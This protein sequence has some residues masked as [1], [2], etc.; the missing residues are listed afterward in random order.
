MP[1]WKPAFPEHKPFKCCAAWHLRK[2]ALFFAVYEFIGGL[3]AGGQ[4]PFFSSIRRVAVFFDTDYESTRRVFKNLTKMGWLKYDRDGRKYWYIPHDGDDGWAKANPGKCNERQLLDFQ[5]DTD[6][7]VGHL[8]AAAGG[9][10][11]VRQ[12]YIDGLRKFTSDTEFLELFR[13]EIAAMKVKRSAGDYFNTAPK[14]CFW[15]VFEYLKAEARRRAV[16][17]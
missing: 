1:T 5:V 3:T 2:P 4:N 17:K 12:G 13:K 9:K 10:F 14:H 11:L 16:N 6:P 7:F 8:Y 15:R